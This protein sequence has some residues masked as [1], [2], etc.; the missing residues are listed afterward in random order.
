MFLDIFNH[1]VH[2]SIREARLSSKISKITMHIIIISS[3]N[4]SGEINTIIHFI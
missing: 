2:M 1:T 4:V 3:M